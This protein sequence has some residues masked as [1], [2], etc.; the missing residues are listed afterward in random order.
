MQ[1]AIL[2]QLSVVTLK[3]R[4]HIGW[5]S[6]KII[7]QVSLGFLLSTNPNIADLLQRNTPEI[8][9]GIAV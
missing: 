4:D 2:L 1:S 3:Y 5:N 8:L 9:A 7:L 6:S